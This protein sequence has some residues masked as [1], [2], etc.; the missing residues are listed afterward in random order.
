MDD[1][2]WVGAHHD[3]VRARAHARLQELTKPLGSL[4]QLELLLERLAEITG[5]VIPTLERPALLLFAADHGVTVEGISAYG[6]EV[7]EEMVTNICMGGAVSSVLARSQGIPVTVVDVGVNSRVRHPAAIVRKVSA[8]TRNLAIEPAMTVEQA[9]QAVEIGQE[10]AT[11]LIDQ[12][13]DILLVGEM[14]IGNT[15]AS[16]AM[17][18]SLLGCDLEQVLGRG[19]GISDVILEQKGQVLRRA[20]SRHQPWIKGPW[21]LLSRLGGFEIGALAGAYVAAAQHHIPILLDGFITTTAA[22]WAIQVEPRVKDVLVASHV[23]HEPGHRLVLEAL[24]LL[25]LLDLGMRLGEGSG[26][27]MAYPVIQLACGVMAKTATFADAQVTKSTNDSVEVLETFAGRRAPVRSGFSEIERTAVYKAIAAR[28]DI[29]VFLPDPI[30]DD[31]LMRILWAAHQGPSVGYMQPW[32]FIVIRNR[33]TLRTIQK[34][35]DNERLRAAEHYTDLRK[36]HYLRLKVEGLLKAPLTICVTNDSSRG[37]PHVLGRNTIPE[38]DLMSTACA[39]ENMWLASRAEG[40]AM[41]WVSMYVKDDLRSIL[42]IPAH[43][44]PVALLSLGYTPHFPAIPLLERVGWGKRLP[45]SDIIFKDRWGIALT[46]TDAPKHR[47][48]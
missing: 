45:L 43:V 28:R 38:T 3:T 33:E 20:L 24:G 23:S 10:M 30:S 29:R 9:H 16:S 35:V 27:L 15:T 6:S 22:L 31:V 25:P 46:P 42:G 21:D 37:G 4:G 13:H 34:G 39:I 1:H 41:G 5:H 36:A 19:T 44:D 2:E 47:P 32:N 14:G 18:A 48:D 26:A 11:R 7:T 8:G 12:E 17:A 40:L